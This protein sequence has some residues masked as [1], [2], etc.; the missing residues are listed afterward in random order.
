MVEEH[1]PHV[2]MDGTSEIDDGDF[3]RSMFDCQMV[4]ID[5]Y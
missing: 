2:P 1:V 4:Y 5:L 3:E